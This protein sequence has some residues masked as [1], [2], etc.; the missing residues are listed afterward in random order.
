RS[1]GERSAGRAPSRRRREEFPPRAPAHQ[2]GG[3]GRGGGGFFGGGGGGRARGYGLSAVGMAAEPPLT[4]MRSPRSFSETSSQR[5]TWTFRSTILPTRITLLSGEK[6]TPCHQWPI[7]A[8][9]S[10]TR[11]VP[12]R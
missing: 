3:G 1:R 2:E 10:P 6:A 12:S 7:H 8:A 4:L 5:S 11:R 9:P